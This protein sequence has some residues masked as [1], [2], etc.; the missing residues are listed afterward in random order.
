MSLP[1]R[2]RVSSDGNGLMMKPV[3]FETINTGSLSHETAA[4]QA[5]QL[6]RV[7]WKTA[8]RTEARAS[9]TLT[10]HWRLSARKKSLVSQ[11]WLRPWDWGIGSVLLSRSWCWC[12]VARFSWETLYIRVLVPGSLSSSLEA[13]I[14]IC[15]ISMTSWTIVDSW[16]VVFIMKTMAATPRKHRIRRLFDT[17]FEDELI[18]E[19]LYTEYWSE[20]RNAER[21]TLPDA[22]H[23]GMS[24]SNPAFFQACTAIIPILESWL[25]QY[26]HHLYCHAV[27]VSLKIYRRHVWRWQKIVSLSLNLFWQASVNL[28]QSLSMGLKVFLCN[29]KACK[30]MSP[31]SKRGETHCNCTT[32]SWE[33]AAKCNG[34]STK[35]PMLQRLI[36]SLTS[37]HRHLFQCYST[38]NKC[39]NL[40]QCFHLSFLFT[41]EK[42]PTF[43]PLWRPL[44][45]LFTCSQ[46]GLLKRFS[47]SGTIQTSRGGFGLH[48]YEF[49]S[50]SARSSTS[51]L[52][53]KSTF[54]F[55]SKSFERS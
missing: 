37:L 19:K 6:N 14:L 9:S 34:F 40:F 15:S 29:V 4:T 17:I 46:L 45:L 32:L 41:G 47:K 35:K 48:W 23:L 49:E 7:A 43:L 8:S 33:I 10:L 12:Q 26:C 28:R 30:V 53:N 2:A 11:P 22:Q 54:E 42:V 27:R 38:K 21:V 18:K 50:M 25:G 3:Q 1:R 31:T 39:Y 13:S 52:V 36:L 51:G 16:R 5:P 55:G 24:D 44:H 20:H